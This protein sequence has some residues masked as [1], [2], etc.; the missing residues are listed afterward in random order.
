MLRMK[1]FFDDILNDAIR[2]MA[3]GVLSKAVYVTQ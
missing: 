2:N 3:D 1:V